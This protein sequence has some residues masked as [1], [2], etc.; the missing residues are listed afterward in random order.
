MRILVVI[1]ATVL[2]V[3]AAVPGAGAGSG[4]HAA[5]LKR[6]GKVSFSGT[7][8]KILVI[9]STRCATARR[10]AR[11]YDRGD[12][13]G[14]WHCALSHGDARYRGRRYGFACGRGGSGGDLKSRP[15]AFIGALT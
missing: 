4:V 15:H 9:R 11:R 3:L 7:T 14:R 12:S 10:V 2:L 8:V 13:T 1:V 5:A 6:C